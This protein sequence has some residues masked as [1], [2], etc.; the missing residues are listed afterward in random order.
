MTREHALDFHEG[1]CFW[2][3]GWRLLFQNRSLLGVALLPILISTGAA[4]ALIWL[5]WVNLP[6]WVQIL[7]TWIGASGWVHHLLYYPL[8]VS[9]AL[10]ALFSSVYVLYLAQSLIAVPF[11][12][13]LADR[14][15]GM[16]GKKPNDQK[17]W[18]EWIAHTFKMV[19]VSLTKFIFLLCVG[20]V[21][22]VFSFLPVLNV[23]T[24]TGAM[25]ILAMDCMDYSLDPFGLGF[26]QRMSYYRRNWAQWLGM[27]AGLALTLLLPGFTLLII[28][29]AVVGAAIIVKSERL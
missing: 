24:L 19:R 28:P 21:L 1:L 27:A 4:A 25:L 17:M 14:T 6:H 16:C 18:R 10:L 12:S 22:F 23:F 3:K 8:L 9:G 11:Y 29:G 5:L 15:L 2:I 13:F 26:R 7:V 20:L